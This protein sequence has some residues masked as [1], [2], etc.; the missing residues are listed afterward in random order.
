[1]IV[2]TNLSITHIEINE[3]NEIKEIKEIKEN[4]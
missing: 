1:M 3:A 2:I 4:Q